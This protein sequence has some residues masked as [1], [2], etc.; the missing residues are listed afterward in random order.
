MK[1][2]DFFELEK[3]LE[4]ISYTSQLGK[5]LSKTLRHFDRYELFNEIESIQDFYY[6]NIILLDELRAKN[7][8]NYRIKS[9]DSCERKYEKYLQGREL[10][11]VFD[12][13]LGLRFALKSYSDVLNK[14]L[15]GTMRLV[16]MTQG[17]ILKNGYSGVHIYYQKDKKSYPIE[18][19]FNT[20]KDRE[21]NDWLHIHV[22][23]KEDDSVGW[24]LRKEYDC[25]KIKNKVDFLEVLNN[26]LSSGKR[27]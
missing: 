8:F 21:F 14:S 4:H 19:Q 12:D 23:K 6:D 3:D 1:D 26:V 13:I 25:G 18:L 24:N 11:K 27:L 10:E 16:N 7:G 20:H 17:N 5:K 9:I 22:Y 15:P 2:L